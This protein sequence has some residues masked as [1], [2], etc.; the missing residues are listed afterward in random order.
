MI[1]W[2][3]T[4]TLYRDGRRIG[5]QYFDYWDSTTPITKNTQERFWARIYDGYSIDHFSCVAYAG[6]DPNPRAHRSLSVG[7]F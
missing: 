4:F 7:E 3:T 6:D 5:G 1:K 2:Q